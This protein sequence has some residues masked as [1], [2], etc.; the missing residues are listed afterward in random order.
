MC[1]MRRERVLKGEREFGFVANNGGD[2]GAAKRVT[3]LAGD[4]PDSAPCGGAA[5]R[6]NLKWLSASVHNVLRRRGGL[7]ILRGLRN[8]NSFNSLSA[9]LRIVDTTNTRSALS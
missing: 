2:E 7:N 4:R 6:R 3:W 5:D 1:G 8:R 9:Y